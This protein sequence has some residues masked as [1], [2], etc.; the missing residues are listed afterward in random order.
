VQ[1]VVS[2]E[3]LALGLERMM[4]LERNR[5]RDGT[6]A[7]VTAICLL[8]GCARSE[9]EPVQDLVAVSIQPQIWL[10]ERIAGELVEVVALLSPGDSPATYQPTDTQISRVL[11]ASVYF[12]IGVP[13]EEGEWFRAITSSGRIR[14]ADIREG[15][16]LRVME[17]GHDHEEDPAA[18]SPE[19]PVGG[20]EPEHEHEHDHSAGGLDPH[21]W[22]SPRLL[23]IQA[24]NIERVLTEL[25]PGQGDTFRANRIALDAE[26]EALDAELREQL[27]PVRGRAI[28]LFHPSWGYFAD[29]YGLHQVP[30]EIDGKEP[31]DAELTRFQTTARNEGVRVIFIQPQITSRTAEILA[32]ALGAEVG[33]LDPLA[34]DVAAN[35]RAAAALLAGALR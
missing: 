18:P 15:I 9:R 30:I 24:A 5:R 17:A 3:R 11:Q 25:Y 8:T 29:D 13:F 7:I 16:E 20:V 1:P 35:L 27:A 12:R 32:E 10:V 33:I 28:F 21:I 34:R 31:S 22:L 26:L 6:A 14:I 19:Q 23:K 2:G 4:N